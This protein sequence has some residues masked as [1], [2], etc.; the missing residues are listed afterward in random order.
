MQ[1]EWLWGMAGGGLIGASA[2]LL[3]AGI[4]RVAGIS[5]ILFQ[6]FTGP[7]RSW[8]LAFL[9]A[10]MLA[11]WLLSATG[12]QLPR[13]EAADLGGVPL[14]LAAGFL[15]GLGTRI[16]SGC[17]SGHGVCGVARLSPRSIAATLS[18]MLLGV[19]TATWLRP[20]VL[21]LVSTP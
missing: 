20:V 8:R 6:A 3:F 19:V 21:E 5:G 2:V 17:T 18:F 11:P 15:V 7:E 9:L 1:A 14:L 16:G 13:L 10:L 4:A 12:W